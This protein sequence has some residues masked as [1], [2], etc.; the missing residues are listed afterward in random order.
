MQH[1]DREFKRDNTA[2]QEH[3]ERY[4]KGQGRKSPSPGM[5]SDYKKAKMH[6][7]RVEHP[8]AGNPVYREGGMTSKEESK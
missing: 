7:G 2:N 3:A 6:E 5:K 8:K 1:K 4:P